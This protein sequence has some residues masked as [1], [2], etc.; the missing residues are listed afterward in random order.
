M[1]SL[2]L[3]S[4]H[5]CAVLVAVSVVLS[6]SVDADQPESAGN[7]R[8][9]S[10]NIRYASPGDGAD[11]WANRVETVAATIAKTDVCGL[12]EVTRPQLDDLRLR[13]PEYDW[14]GVGR[15][16]GKDGGEFSPVF[17]KRERFER[18]EKGTFWLSSTPEKI[19]S[20]GWDA[21]LPRVLSWVVLR[22]RTVDKTF[23]FGSTHFDHRGATARIESGKLIRSRSASVPKQIAAILAGDF[24]CLPD[25][26][27]YDA[28][29]SGQSPAIID[30]R[31][32]AASTAAGSPNSTWCGF[33][34]IAP[35]RIIDHIFV[36]GPVE[37]TEY[38]VWNPKTQSDRFGSDHLP[39]VI[40]AALR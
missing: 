25:S 22:D 31:Q 29:V 24:N 39:V 36:T 26:E 33:K 1:Y 18:L 23:W 27:P 15:D 4:L 32:S 6:A 14:Y 20:K 21:A 9:M 17:Y 37:V 34:E 12:Q 35:G 7:L 10:Y 5:G 30:A 19:G 11:V 38:A 13:L 3:Q 2:S 40:N 16:D 8:L 28:I